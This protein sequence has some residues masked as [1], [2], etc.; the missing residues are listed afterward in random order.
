M[1]KSS[2]VDIKSASNPRRLTIKTKCGQCDHFERSPYYG[3][4]CS[5][6]GIREF[7]SPC[8]H[9][10]VSPLS[11]DFQGTMSAVHMARLMRSVRMKDLAALAAVINTEHITRKHG[12]YLGQPVYLRI[13]SPGTHLNHYASAHVV[14]ADAKKVY[15]QG[16]SGFRAEVFHRS[17][18]TASV[19]ALMKKEMIEAGRVVC[20]KAS[21]YQ[22][23]EGRKGKSSI[24]NIETVRTIQPEF[25]AIEGDMA[26]L[27]RKSKSKGG[28][29]TV[30]LSANSNKAKPT[31]TKAKVPAKKA[32]AG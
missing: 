9:F 31:T 21:R 29:K 1:K 23:L 30:L 3:D 11:V 27:D 2:N 22:G 13:F 6:L 24:M 8:N 4:V 12:F 15:V 16:T 28:Y 5:K 18:I 7:S 26:T 25:G 19:F 10:K 32:K 17:V 20:P 14:S